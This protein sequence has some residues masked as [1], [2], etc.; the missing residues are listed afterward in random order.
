MGSRCLIGAEFQFWS[1]ERAMEMDVSDGY[2][3][4]QIYR[5]PLNCTLKIV[6]R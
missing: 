4:L 6:R 2:T 5:M 3:K 1:M